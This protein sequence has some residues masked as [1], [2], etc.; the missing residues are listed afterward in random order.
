MKTEARKRGR[1]VK[2]VK[3][4]QKQEIRCLGSDK[5]LW[6]EAALT[7]GYDSISEWARAV[8]T[9]SAKRNVAGSKT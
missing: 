8:L 3:L 9:K 2:D 4:D 5:T 7:K 1:P 6:R